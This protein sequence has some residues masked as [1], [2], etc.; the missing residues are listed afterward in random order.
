MRKII[1][2]LIVACL[3]MQLMAQV[4]CNQSARPL[5]IA[6]LIGDKLVRETPFAYRLELASDSK[7]FDGIQMIDFGRNFTVSGK[8]SAFAYTQLEAQRDMEMNIQLGHS[9]ACSIWLNGKL[10]YRNDK[11]QNLEIIYDERSIEL[12]FHFMAKL[13]KGS[14]S[15]LIK[16]VVNRTDWR[17]YL[18]P[19]SSKGTV[20]E[21]KIINPEIGLGKIELIDKRISAISNWLII[22]PFAGDKDVEG[23]LSP[24]EEPVFG[25]MFQGSNGLLTWTIPRVDVI[26]NLINPL[27][28]GTNYDWNYHNGGVAWAMKMLGEISGEM[29]Y[30]KYAD[31]FCDFQIHSIPFVKY[32]IETMGKTNVPNGSLVNTPLLDFTLAPSLPFIYRLRKENTFSNRDE[33]KQFIARMLHYARYEQIRLPGSSNF[34]RT[35]PQ[36]YTTWVDDMFMGIPFLVQASLYAE[37][38]ADRKYFL[39]D[40]ASQVLDF[41]K[42]VWDTDADLYVHAHYSSNNDKMAH[43]SRANGW[44]IW[45][46]S[47][48]LLHLP[49]EHPKYKAILKCYQKHV[50]S[51]TSLQDEV[52][53]WHN[54]LDH[55][56]S[57][58]EVSG[59][60]IFTM[61][62]ARGVNEG[63]ISRKKYQPIA[64]KGWN[65]LTTQVEA[66][67]TVH[68]ICYGT[69]CSSDINYYMNRPF[70]DNDTHGL[71]AVLFAAM[72]IH[73]M[74]ND[75]YKKQLR[76]NDQ[77]N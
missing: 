17:V 67:G 61:A 70:Y 64:Q 71:F 76:T 9:D 75:N 24:T 5:D 37:D 41:N 3:E 1:L 46:T 60:A 74:L 39:D 18:Q 16:S 55:P 40:A 31:D 27:E 77:Y 42:Q 19:P 30:E 20:S 65:A 50:E 58:P 53:F 69:M 57:K 44:G 7:I 25:Q 59:T 54:V 35:T 36:K 12:P 23:I 68:N 45:A 29:K 48:V 26:G 56:E 62:I 66:N 47:E 38:E 33:Y 32:E 52:G 43:W 51:L 34:T 8:T 6:R 11:E 10:V 28:W 63:W 13:K 22:G 21:K 72:E 73:K 15:L 14:N 2:L 49:K 4:D